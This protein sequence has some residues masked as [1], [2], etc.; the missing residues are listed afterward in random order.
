MMEI[1]KESR[2]IILT[3]ILGDLLILNALFYFVAFIGRMPIQWDMM[4]HCVIMSLCYLVSVFMFSG[5]T[6]HRRRVRTDQILTAVVGNVS[7]F[8]V[9]WFAMLSILDVNV[10]TPW[11]LV[12]FFVLILLSI[13]GYRLLYQT[14]LRNL[15]KR[16]GHICNVVFVGSTRNMRELYDEMNHSH[17]GY[18]VIGYFDTEPNPS[19]VAKYLGHCDNAV[20]YIASNES[21]IDR[22]YCSL[23]SAM[24]DVILPIIS[25]C[26]NHMVRFYSVP[27]LRN[28]LQ[29]R[30]NLEMFSNTPVLSIRTEPLAKSDNKIVK[31][32]FDIIF[33]GLFIITLYPIVLLIFAPLIKL[34]SRGP[35]F[36]R[37]KRNGIDGKEFWCYKFRSMKESVIADEVQA[38]ED[39]PRKTKIG[40]F[41]RR[42]N[43]D[44]LPQ[45]MNVLMGDMSIVGPRPH[46]LKHTAEYSALIG[47]YM[48]RHLVK[49][50]V[51]GWAQVTGFRGETKELLEMEGRVKADIWYMEH[52]TFMLDLYIIY[53]TVANVI[54]RKDKKA[55]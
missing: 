18:R 42:T 1:D 26:D 30:V 12:L 17:T 34:S 31:R 50:G 41:M 32:T 9:V 46:M 48:V 53:K 24:K 5:V 3:V 39:D 49:P 43:I 47:T 16:G 14:I 44:E 20:E 15:R 40:D 37:Q 28:Y 23:P 8:F 4:H 51:T 13:V 52:W 2:F 10:M 6:L 27:N 36:F 22:L 19:F 25:C 29:R 54:G 7:G 11:F 21:N 45:F 33:S 55:F 35:V 38:T